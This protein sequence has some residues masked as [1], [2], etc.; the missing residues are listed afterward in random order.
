MLTRCI[1]LG[2]LPARTDKRSLSSTCCWRGF[3]E[4]PAMEVGTICFGLKCWGKE[5]QY[6]FNFFLT[7]IFNGSS[8][9]QCSGKKQGTHTITI[10]KKSSAVCG[11]LTWPTNTTHHGLKVPSSA[12][13]LHPSWPIPFLLGTHTRFGS[14][15]ENKQA[16]DIRFNH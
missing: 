12:I 15:S 6:C 10:K 7:C 13:N 9:C 3:S 14:S 1:W 8:D 16:S 2:F 4:I 5:T 11:E